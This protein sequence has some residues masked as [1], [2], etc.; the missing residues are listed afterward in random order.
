MN[1]RFAAP[2]DGTYLFC[3][4]LLYKVNASTSARMSGRLVLNGAT[5]IRGSR[6]KSSAQ[7]QSWSGVT[8]P[9]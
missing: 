9:M 7:R 6:G 2:S 4:T 1:N 3:A 8:R 5:K